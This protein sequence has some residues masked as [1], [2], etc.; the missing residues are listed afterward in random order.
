METTLKEL[1]RNVKIR[2][3]GGAKL[4]ITKQEEWQRERFYNG[5]SY[6]V[7]LF[8]QGRRMTFDFWD[9]LAGSGTDFDSPEASYEMLD[10]LLSGTVGEEYGARNF[11]EF[12]DEFGYDKDS[13][14]AE[15]IFKACMKQ[16]KKLEHLLG[17][18]MK[19]FV[20][21]DRN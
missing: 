14:K 9:S 21:S 19:K 2:L 11:E 13:R 16:T 5:R 20:F 15:A 10:N 6:N 12:A 8:Y 4:P 17:E 1:S 7:T 18:D 3:N